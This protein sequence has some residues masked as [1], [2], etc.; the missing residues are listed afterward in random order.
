V[1]STQTPLGKWISYSG[2]FKNSKFEGPGSLY[3]QGGEK[4]VGHFQNGYACGEGLVY[5]KNGEVEQGNWRN[6]FLVDTKK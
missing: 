2:E 1:Y 5:K 4:F 3:L 6:N